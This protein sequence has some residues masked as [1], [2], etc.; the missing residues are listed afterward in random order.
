M[1]NKKKSAKDF[2]K[3]KGFWAQVLNT[4]ALVVPGP[5]KILIGIAGTM[6]GGASLTDPARGPL[7]F[8]KPIEDLTQPEDE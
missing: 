3:S 1:P 5:A 8:K 2:Y 6:L 4:V 7:E